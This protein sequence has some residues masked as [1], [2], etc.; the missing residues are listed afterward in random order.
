MK[1]TKHGYSG[2]RIYS[3]WRDMKK[4]CMNKGH[5]FY[6][7]YGA[8]GVTVCERWLIFANFLAD[9]G[10][11]PDGMSLD[12]IDN[13]G[14]Y[15]PENCRWATN[16]EQHL[17]SR[18]ARLIT[19]NGRTLGRTQ[20]EKELGLGS[21]TLFRRLQKGMSLKDALQPIKRGVDV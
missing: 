5:R 8:R 18:Q 17:N 13:D 6:K 10:E 19:F 3:L 2:T 16:S 4:R 1:R 21:G 11:R 20:W 7:D 9:M 12:R 15:S 14:P